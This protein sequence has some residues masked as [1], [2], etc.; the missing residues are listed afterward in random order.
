L[1]DVEVLIGISG[2]IFGGLALV[3][4]GLSYREDSKS[5]YLENL[6][7][8]SNEIAALESS[9]ERNKDYQLFG[10]K[11]L[12][13]LDRL[14]NLALRKIIP[15]HLA[16]YFDQNFAAALGLLSK[17]QFKQ[18]SNDVVHLTT[19]CNNKNIRAGTAPEPH[20]SSQQPNATVSTN[21]PNELKKINYNR[22]CYYDRIISYTKT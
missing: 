9:Q 6:T 7:K 10:A 8:I 15:E 5:R 22:Y 1:V 20:P 3:F 4:T 12:L 18:Y 17:D 14:A 21:L 13:L 19:W 16:R 2:A 11:Y